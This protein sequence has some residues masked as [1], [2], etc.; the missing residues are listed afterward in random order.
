MINYFLV[1]DGVS[2]DSDV[3]LVTD[4]VNLKIEPTQS[5]RDA[6]RDKMCIYVFIGV[7]VYSYINTYVYT[8]FKKRMISCGGDE[9][10]VAAGTKRLEVAKGNNGVA[11]LCFVAKA[12]QLVHGLSCLTDRNDLCCV[13]DSAN[14]PAEMVSGFK[15]KRG[16]RGDL[17]AEW[18]RSLSRPGR[19]KR[20]RNE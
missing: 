12:S 14:E 5:F 20:E 8:V 17:G 6:H 19:S 1:K 15:Q 9:V 7:S 10:V 16:R 13:C 3:L 18:T 4:F 2:V 11:R